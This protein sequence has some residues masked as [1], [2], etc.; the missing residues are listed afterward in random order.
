MLG[1]G[2]V[3]GLGAGG[4]DAVI[5]VYAAE[6]FSPRLVSWLHASWSAGAALGPLVMTAV[7]AAGLAWRWG[8]AV[9]AAVLAAMALSFFATA[10]LWG[11][12]AAAADGPHVPRPTSTFLRTLRRPVVWAHMAVFFLY[13]GLEGGAGQWA[14]T[15]LTEARQ[16]PPRT[17]GTWA[18][19]YWASLAV[20]RVVCGIAASRFTVGAL[21]RASM[22]VALAAAVLVWADL[23]PD[24]T[25]AG[26]SLLGFAL[27]PI[28]PLLIAST[29]ARLGAEHA[30][31]A[32]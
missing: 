32:I 12:P 23:G 18:G 22:V 27:S 3:G 5:N 10:G 30:A 1:C 28:F 7:L 2:L 4:I 16:I 13:T 24:A 31:H 6:R 19:G 15:L 25:L 29:P 20:G 26:L 8:Y 9:V 11:G 17:A 14:Y 21:L